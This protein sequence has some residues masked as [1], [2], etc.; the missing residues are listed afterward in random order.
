MR[1]KIFFILLLGFSI[2]LSAQITG[3]VTST[4]GDTL[5]FVNI[6]IKN[7]D[8]GTTANAEGHY[9]LD[10]EKLG[11]YSLTFQFLGYRTRDITVDISHLPFTLNTVLSPETTT[12]DAVVVHSGI[13]PANA[14]IRAMIENKDKILAKRKAYTA[15]FYSRGLWK[16]HNAPEKVFGQKIGDLGGGLDSTRT[17]IVYLSETISKI[18]VREPN[19]FKEIITASKVSGDDNGFSFNSAQEADFSFYE[20]TLKI[21]TTAMVSPIATDAFGYYDYKL[22]GS[23]YEGSALINKIQV[24]PKRVNDRIFSGFIYVVENAWQLYGVDL[25][26]TGSAIQVPFIEQ[27]H[28][29]HNFKYDP[30]VDLWVKISQT[31]DFSFKLFGFGGDGRFTAFYSNYDFNTDFNKKSFTN[32]VLSFAAEANKKDSLYWSGKRP[33]PLT[34]EEQHDYIK[35][36]SLQV[37][38]KSQKYQDSV[39]AMGNRIKLLDPFLGYTFT[40]TYARWR[41]H[42]TGLLSGLNFNTLQGFNI[43]SGIDYA[44]WTEDYK[45]ATS[46]S[47]QVNYGFSDDQLRFVGQLGKRFNRKNRRTLIVRAGREVKQFN[48]GE[49]IPPHVN[50]IATLLWERNYLKAYDL[51]SARIEYREEVVNGIQVYGQLGYEKRAPLFN[52]SDFVFIKNKVDYTSNNPYAPQDFANAAITQHKIAKLG[53]TAQIHFDQKYMSYPNGKFNVEDSKYPRLDLTWEQGFAADRGALNYTQLNARLSQQ[54]DLG[55]SGNFGFNLKAGTFTHAE[56]ISFVDYQHFYG[57]QTR[58]NLSGNRLNGFDI[59]PYYRFSTNKSYAE[60]HVEHNFKGF[61][62]GKIPGLRALNFNLVAGAK[63]LVTQTSKPYQELSIGLDNV[64]FGK[65]RFLR[66]DYVRSFYEGDSEGAFVFGVGIGF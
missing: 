35:K 63:A 26:T 47:L 20:N 44:S 4:A 54:L 34:G 49:A 10:I 53:L 30:S 9:V 37:I 33:V 51:T 25:S 55:N 15:N 13:N 14:M 29:K 24:I 19:D 52:R 59:L 58:V 23:F 50:S 16:V 12:L 57:N 60:A 40:N 6:Y 38:R 36:D 31:I 8:M 62:L 42:F 46:A 17:G 39:D 3:R 61:I 41:I 2:A 45:S 18:R 27:L 22:V 43:S 28:F 32:E 48:A 64:G 5:S 21:N 7:S 1:S 11:H 66:V 65:F 56:G